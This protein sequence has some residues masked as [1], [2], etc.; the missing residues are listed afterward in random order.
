MENWGFKTICLNVYKKIKKIRRNSIST[1]IYFAM[2]KILKYSLN[3]LD[4]IKLKNKRN[5]SYTKNDHD[6]Y[7][8]KLFKKKDLNISVVTPS[9][10]VLKK[11]NRFSALEI[12]NE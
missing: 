8:E 7:K 3:F 10:K 12:V 2:I 9:K 6:F 5:I 4:K 11:S 1:R